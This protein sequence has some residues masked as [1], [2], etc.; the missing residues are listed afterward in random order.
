M[1]WGG[2]IMDGLLSGDVREE[3]EELQTRHSLIGISAPP[4]WSLWKHLLA[5][6][7][8]GQDQRCEEQGF[9]LLPA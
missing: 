6:L 3:R 9:S 1:K 5:Q 4:P 7:S 8:L 2:D